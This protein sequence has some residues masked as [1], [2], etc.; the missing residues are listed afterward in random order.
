MSLHV[1]SKKLTAS[2]ENYIEGKQL[3]G[4]TSQ[5][6]IPAAPAAALYN[7]ESP[8][9][10]RLKTAPLLS[11]QTMPQ[12]TRS[13]CHYGT[14]SPRPHTAIDR[15][16]SDSSS[17]TNYPRQY[18]SGPY[19]TYAHVDYSHFNNEDQALWKMSQSHVESK[20]SVLL[21]RLL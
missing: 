3:L 17:S 6:N 20:Y 4:W 18:S 10:E 21:S 2:P 19:T 15:T 8:Y 11:C 14:N 12:N 5:T 9:D 16:A 13:T 1:L 7:P